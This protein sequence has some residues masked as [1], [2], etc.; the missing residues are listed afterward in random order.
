[1]ASGFEGGKLH[2]EGEFW[3]ILALL[4]CGKNKD[5]A[6]EGVSIAKSKVTIGT[7]SWL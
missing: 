7:K 6:E 1:V 2:E 4:D 3:K 5:C